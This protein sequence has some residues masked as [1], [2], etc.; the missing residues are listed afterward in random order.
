MPG[1]EQRPESIFVRTPRCWLRSHTIAAA[2]IIMVASGCGEWGS[3][4][5]F[6]GLSQA[7]QQ[8]VTKLRA[9]H[10]AV[11]HTY[12]QQPDLVERHRKDLQADP[13]QT[14]AAL[15]PLQSFVTRLDLTNTPL[16]DEQFQRLAGFTR[17]QKLVLWRVPIT[18][19]VL[20]LIADFAELNELNLGRT[21]IREGH[22][23]VLARLKRLE[24]L[25][26]PTI[27][28]AVAK[29]LANITTLQNIT[30]EHTDITEAGGAAL[31]ELQQLR[32]L[33]L[34]SATLGPNALAQ[35]AKL[36]HLEVLI[37]A[38][39]QLDD[40]QLAE[41]SNAPSLREL[42]LFE[43]K[44]GDDGMA[45]VGRIA[46]LEQL[47]I[48]N[49]AVGDAGLKHLAALQNLKKIRFKG[50]QITFEGRYAAKQFLPHVE[51]AEY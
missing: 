23:A 40:P 37:L 39:A 32:K 34:R 26:V 10:F 11:L 3:R 38:G 46:P 13:E 51:F 16:T 42:D 20:P 24:T 33:E 31:A 45:H 7:Q 25:F 19:N 4:H 48:A 28:D 17:L 9:N 8:A 1:P 14:I 15:I 22:Y 35:V 50:S 18:D 41:L 6:P 29:E 27:D 5:E 36:P 12:S 43:T 47:R 30:A 2:T 49:T 21:S 44:V